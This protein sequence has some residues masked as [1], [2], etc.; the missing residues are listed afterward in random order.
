MKIEL[1]LSADQVFCVA[2]MIE[3]VYD[4]QTHDVQQKVMKSIAIDIADKFTR[5]QLELHNK[6]SLFDAKKKYKVSLKFHEAFAL[7][8]VI[9]LLINTITDVYCKT[10]TNK[11]LDNLNQ[12][13]A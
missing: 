1:K 12:Q 8:E 6:Q 9:R 4:T 5:K 13:L 3:Q 2:K 10:I 11:V 7:S